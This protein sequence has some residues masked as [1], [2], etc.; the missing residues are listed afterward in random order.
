MS[1]K[2]VSIFFCSFF[3]NNGAVLHRQD[4]QD[5]YIRPDQFKL[6]SR[7]VYCPKTINGINLIVKYPC[8]GTGSLSIHNATETIHHILGNQLSSLAEGKGTVIMKKNII[9]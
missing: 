1:P 9:S 2:F 6:K 8:P 4:T 3:G 7:V 5:R